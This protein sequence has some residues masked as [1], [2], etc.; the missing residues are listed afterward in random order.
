VIEWITTFT[1]EVDLLRELDERECYYFTRGYWDKAVSIC[2]M[3]SNFAQRL[4]QPVE[5]FD[6]L[7]ESFKFACRRND[8]IEARKRLDR[9]PGMI[10]SV[11][12][13]DKLKTSYFLSI[14]NYWLLED[15]VARSEE[16]LKEALVLAPR[17]SEK[18]FLTARE[19][20]A[21]LLYHRGDTQEA[22]EAMK[23]VLREAV[24]MPS[25]QHILRSQYILASI[26]LDQGNI[27]Q[28]AQRLSHMARMKHEERRL[29]A[30]TQVLKARLCA[31]QGDLVSAQVCFTNA[32]DLFERLGI[33]IELAEASEELAR[34]EAQMAEA[35]E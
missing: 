22:K 29:S 12:V 18:M 21:A 33:P 8:L 7:L 2:D 25:K 27:E 10:A 9:L 6:A 23:Q 30:R 31:L 4:A 20:M 1:S 16:A 32:I 24:N 34:L 28:A 17:V 3:R 26:D 5:E 35:A 13:P 15:E 14:A 11:N 19:R